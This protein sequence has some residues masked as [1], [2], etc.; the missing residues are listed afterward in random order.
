MKSFK[1]FGL[2]MGMLILA[3]IACGGGTE[4][5]TQ[6]ATEAPTQ[7]PPTE[8]PPTEEGTASLEIINNSSTDIW[9]L[10]VA[11][12]SDT[13]W[14][15]D[16][17]GANI[18]YAGESFTLTDVPYGTY[19]LLVE[20]SSH[21]TIETWM[22]VDIYEDLTWEVFGTAGG[23]A[24]LE[25]INASGTDIWYLYVSP[26]S[27]TTWGNDLLG[28]NIIPTGESYV[29]SD[30]P[31]GTYDLMVEDSN[32]NPIETWMGV[33][34]AGFPTWTVRGGG[35]IRQ[36]ASEAAASSEYGNPNWSA[37]QTTGEPDTAECGDYASAWASATTG[38]VEWLELAYATPVIPTEINIHETYTPGFIIRVE[39][40]DLVAGYHVVWE[41]SPTNVNSCPR[42]FS[43]L[44]PDIDF[45]VA[46]IR[47]TLDQ[48]NAPSWNEIDAVELVG[49][50]AE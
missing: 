35:M 33:D 31:A 32:H 30:I 48:T 11:P 21:N 22:G 25:I 29:L 8:A 40:I 5:P 3:T 43:I 41:G 26:S 39:V 45:P 24:S 4:A 20:D 16:Q 50:A 27:S 2:A 36:W 12:S 46:G 44:V 42:I 15:D 7:A 23:T 13:D 1:W 10:Y 28:A 17:L 19:D 37:M 9:Y 49:I 14:G 6:A 18:L 47:I 38:D 34:I